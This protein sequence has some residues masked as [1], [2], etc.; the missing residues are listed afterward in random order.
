MPSVLVVHAHDATMESV[1]T[2]ARNFAHEAYPDVDTAE[3]R[4]RPLDS[5]SVVESDDV[6]YPLGYTVFEWGDA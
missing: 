3:W 6:Y 1:V 5:R 2:T 4:A